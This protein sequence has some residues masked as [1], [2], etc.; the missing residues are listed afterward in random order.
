[1]LKSSLYDYSNA[2][3]P[4]S[5]KITAVGAETDA[6]AIAPVKNDKKAIFKNCG[7]LTDCINEKNNTEVDNAEDLYVV[8]PLYNLIEY[9][10]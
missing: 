9:L 2:Y 10:P 5:G 1:M 7:P 8:M 3:I 4:L 6:A